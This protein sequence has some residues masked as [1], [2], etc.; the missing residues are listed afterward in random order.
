M[1]KPAPLQSGKKAVRR[2]SERR[3]ATNVSL[4][5]KLLDEARA[6]AVNVSRACERGLALQI[7]EERAKHWRKTNR[8]AI[9]SSNDFAA[10]LG[11]PLA[12][13]RQF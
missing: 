10:R 4:D 5:A 7:A 3:R 11:L 13:Y 8:A 12:R 6:L 9:E 1:E 2:R